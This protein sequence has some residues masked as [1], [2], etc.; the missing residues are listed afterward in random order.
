MIS[1]TSGQMVFKWLGLVCAIG[2]G[3][4]TFGISLIDVTC[5]LFGKTDIVVARSENVLTQ[6]ITLAGLLI[7][8]LGAN[9]FMGYKERVDSII[10][11]DP[12]S[13][14]RSTDDSTE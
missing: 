1:P 13:K 11:R 8:A 14:T 5:Q 2:I 12:N 7:T 4:R 3:Y 10:N 9:R 6:L